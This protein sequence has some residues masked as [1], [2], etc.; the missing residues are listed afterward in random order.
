MAEHDERVK[1]TL[2]KPRLDLMPPYAAR[3]IGK[4]LEVGTN[5]YEPWRWQEGAPWSV[6]LAA[7]ERHL[8]EWKKGEADDPDGFKHLAAVC[9]HAMFLMEHERLGIGKDDRQHQ[10]FKEQHP[11]LKPEG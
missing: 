6:W 10:R 11:E 1:Q 9:V 3:E 8:N 2:G 4:C 7:L 5:K